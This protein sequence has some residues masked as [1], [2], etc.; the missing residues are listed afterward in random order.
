MNYLEYIIYYLYID[1]E[2]T[3][4]Q[5]LKYPCKGNQIFTLIY[6]GVRMDAT[7]PALKMQVPGDSTWPFDPLVGG[8]LTFPKGHFFTIPKRSHWITWPF[9]FC[10]FVSF[11]NQ[12]LVQSVQHLIGPTMEI[13]VMELQRFCEDRNRGEV[14]GPQLMPEFY[15]AERGRSSWPIILWQFWIFFWGL[16]TFEPDP[17]WHN[18]F[19]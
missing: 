18:Q 10:C 2:C 1:E 6:P 5:M 13:L 12:P 16:Q 17:S 7:N 4:E 19:F 15:T 14:L 8:H 3:R 9:L 11:S